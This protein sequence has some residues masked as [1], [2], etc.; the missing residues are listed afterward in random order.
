MMKERVV[1]GLNPQR[2]TVCTGQDGVLVPGPDSTYI[3]PYCEHL[4]EEEDEG[5]TEEGS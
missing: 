4:L 2:C 3:H 5:P 1:V